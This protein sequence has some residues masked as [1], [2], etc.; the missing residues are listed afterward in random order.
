M[1]V[2]RGKPYGNY[3]FL[4]DLGT[5]NISGPE[6]GFSEVILPET[7]IDVIQYRNGNE[8]ESNVRKIPGRARYGND[9]N[10]KFT[11]HSGLTYSFK[12]FAA[13]FRQNQNRGDAHKH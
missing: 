12:H 1:A 2:L 5:G 9:S 13:E 4:V 7:T 11:K 10:D 8:P 6:A 3:N